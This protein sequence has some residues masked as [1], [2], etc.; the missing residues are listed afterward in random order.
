MWHPSVAAR[1][2]AGSQGAAGG[3]GIA[4]SRSAAEAAAD[5]NTRGSEAARSNDVAGASRSLE[6]GEDQWSGAR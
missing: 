2:R 6:A 5:A 3:V 1:S 4:S